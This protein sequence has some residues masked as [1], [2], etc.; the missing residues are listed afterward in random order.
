MSRTEKLLFVF[1]MLLI[2]VG[3]GAVRTN[4]MEA[5]SQQ[6]QSA[7][8]NITIKINSVPE[9]RYEQSGI[10]KQCIEI[11]SPYG[12]KDQK[13]MYVTGIKLA[14]TDNLFGSADYPAG[15]IDGIDRGKAFESLARDVQDN[16]LFL[17]PIYSEVFFLDNTLIVEYQNDEK[18]INEQVKWL[19]DEIQ[20]RY[21]IKLIKK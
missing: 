19:I 17:D 10:E 12:S 20:K 1:A 5:D 18:R 8:L 21:S 2:A 3:V 9:T 4:F 11:F 14:F 7:Q 16:R 6:P 13:C 15:M